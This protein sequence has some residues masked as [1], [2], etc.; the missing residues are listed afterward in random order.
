MLGISCTR[1]LRRRLDSAFYVSDSPSPSEYAYASLTADGFCRLLA[2]DGFCSLQREKGEGVLP[3]VCRL[4]PRSFKGGERAELC[5]SASCEGVVEALM[6]QPRPLSF[7]T[8]TV[9]APFVP[10]PPQRAGSAEVRGRCIELLQRAGLPLAERVRE[11]GGYIT[12]VA[13]PPFGESLKGFLQDALKLIGAFDTVSPNIAEY[14]DAALA[15][16]GLDEQVSD[17]AVRRYAEA[18]AAAHD[19][20]PE[21]EGYFENLGVNHMFYEQFPYA[22]ANMAA[23][24]AALRAAYTL[25]RFIAVCHARCEAEFADAA[26]AANRY[27]EHSSFYKNAALLIGLTVTREAASSDDDNNNDNDNAS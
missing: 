26:S 13:Q 3:L 1:G 2:P 19:A 18:E 11:V 15:S 16:I 7:S 23:A 25:C 21:I 6:R 5:C 27:I 14:G 24:Y 4:Y 20:L 9:E 22:A 12:G 17:E 10:S 8:F